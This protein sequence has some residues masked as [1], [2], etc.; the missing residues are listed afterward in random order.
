MTPVPLTQLPWTKGAFV[1]V[2]N[3]IVLAVRADMSIVPMLKEP[4]SETVAAELSPVASKMIV[5][6]ASG[7]LVMEGA[8]PLVVAHA[9]DLQLPPAAK[10]QYLFTPAANVIPLLPLQS[11]KRGPL[12]GAAAPAIVMSRKSMSVGAATAAQV[13]VRAVPM[14]SDRTNVRIE[15]SVPADSVSVPLMVWLPVHEIVDTPDDVRPVIVRLLKIPPPIK[16]TV[17]IE[18]L[19]RLKL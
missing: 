9:A 10:F 18:V 7:K 12:T 6:C 16:F 14:V 5:S 8:P 4:A 3:V 11:P 19:V 2:A 17:P 13:S 15:A 1:A